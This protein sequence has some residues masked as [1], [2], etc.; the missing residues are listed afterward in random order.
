M[1]PITPKHQERWRWISF[2]A[3]AA[4]AYF[5][6]IGLNIMPPEPPLPPIPAVTEYPDIHEFIS[7]DQVPEPINLAEIRK[8]IGYPGRALTAGIE[9]N[10][11]AR[12][13]VS[14]KGY[15]V[16]H[17]MIRT[18]H[19]IL[20][21][22]VEKHLHKLLFRPASNEG[23]PIR[24]WVNVPITFEIT[25]EPDINKW[26]VTEDEPEE[27]NLNEVKRAIGY[28]ILARE[29]GIQ[30]S[31]VVRILVNEKGYYV[32]HKVIKKV[33]PI[34]SEEVEKHL[35]KLRFTPAMKDGNPVKFW[36]NVPFRFR[37]DE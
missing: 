33:H 35:P 31:V 19:P 25:E 14:E 11:I 24:F 4:T 5:W 15:Y 26:M 28:P 6:A 18:V 36:V 1:N 32:R 8:E 23:H 10:V 2:L 17:N 9:G 7:A 22:E 34:L 3:L 13:L 29:A 16:R 30:G 27:L 21:Q 20:E 37:L 12:V